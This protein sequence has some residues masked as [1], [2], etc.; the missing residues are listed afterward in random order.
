MLGPPS[1]PERTSHNH[2]ERVSQF[3]GTEAFAIV[4][5]LPISRRRRRPSA[6]Y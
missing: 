2:A 3:A 5:D 1:P 6:D 4:S